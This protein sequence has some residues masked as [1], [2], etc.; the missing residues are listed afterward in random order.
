[1][2]RRQ[3]KGTNLYISTDTFEK[4]PL[5]LLLTPSVPNGA[6]NGTFPAKVCKKR[7]PP[8]FRTVPANPC[9]C[10]LFLLVEVPLQQASERLAMAGFISPSQS[11]RKSLICAASVAKRLISLAFRAGWGTRTRGETGAKSREKIH[12]HTGKDGS[13]NGR[14]KTGLGRVSVGGWKLGLS[15][16]GAD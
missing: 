15:L 12:P 1:M 7:E 9:Y 4:A 11:R 14:K 3:G 10:L 5:R 6:R 8:F 16:Q 13:S 2:E